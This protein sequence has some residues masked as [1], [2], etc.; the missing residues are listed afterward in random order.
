MVAPMQSVQGI[1]GVF[2]Y[3]RD[4]AALA[5]WYT[6]HLGIEFQEWGSAR[7]VEFP[8]A[9]V[10]PGARMATTTFSIFQAEGEVGE[11]TGRVNYRVSDLDAL[12]ASL[13]AAG[14][15]TKREPDESYG[16]FAYAFDPEG[17]KIEL[18]E[19]PLKG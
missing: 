17:N 16:R 12:C 11:K 1:G 10:E 7:G 5:A 9:D 18:W 14:V 19:P 2:L 13:K 3:A 4:A 6:Q 8:S 15:A